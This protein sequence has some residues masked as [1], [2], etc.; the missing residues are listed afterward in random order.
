R[1]LLCDGLAR[2]VVEERLTVVTGGTDLGIF[3]LFGAG[4]SGGTATVIG[5]ATARRVPSDEAS[6]RESVPLESHHTHF[7]LVED[8]DWG[9]ETPGSCSLLAPRSARARPRSLYSQTVGASPRARCSVTSGKAA[10]SS[11]S[12]E[13]DASQKRSPRWSPAA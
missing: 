2:V 9:D 1:L 4:R 6:S 8:A 11:C 7:V 12:Q 5:V 10:R 3:R 13:V